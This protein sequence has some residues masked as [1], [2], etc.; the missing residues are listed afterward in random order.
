MRRRTTAR[1]SI[2]AFVLSAAIGLAA[3]GSSDEGGSGGKTIALLLPE[4]KTARYEAHD[5]PDFTAEVKRLCPDCTVFYQNASQDPAKQETQAEAAITKGADVLV[6]DAVD[7]KGAAAT[8][9]RAKQ[10]NIPVIAYD[11]LISG[12]PIDYYV[13]F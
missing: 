10:S 4:T 5:R 8:V 3:C 7:A 12:A 9:K 6:L 2:A 11:R 13:S 1:L